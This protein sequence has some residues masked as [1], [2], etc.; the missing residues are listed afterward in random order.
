MQCP[1]A[2]VHMRM[3]IG[4]RVTAAHH[5]MSDCKVTVNQQLQQA[6]SYKLHCVLWFK[7]QD[8]TLLSLLWMV[9]VQVYS[10]SLSSEVDAT[11]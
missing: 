6:L 4:K 9:R 3:E 7:S 5:S 8:L 10:K 2:C 11:T 1:N